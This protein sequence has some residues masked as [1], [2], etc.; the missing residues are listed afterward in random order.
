[1]QRPKNLEELV[2]PTSFKDRLWE[3][4][5][6]QPSWAHRWAQVYGGLMALG[7]KSPWYEADHTSTDAGRLAGYASDGI[8]VARHGVE[9]PLYVADTAIWAL[10]SLGYAAKSIWDAG[11]HTIA[12]LYQLGR[13]GGPGWSD[14]MDKMHQELLYNRSEMGNFSLLPW[15]AGGPENFVGIGEWA[16][17]AQFYPLT[18]ALGIA[19]LYGVGK[20]KRH[21]LNKRAEPKV[22]DDE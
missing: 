20:W 18:A 4:V 12:G 22:D 17:K 13:Y 19:V 6:H 8:E 10:K 5:R 1:M 16:D 9:I 14:A 7:I 11:Y 2:G 15:H 21:T 3:Y